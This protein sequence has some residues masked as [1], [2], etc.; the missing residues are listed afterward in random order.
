MI[1][2]HSKANFMWKT[3]ENILKFYSSES[4]MEKEGKTN[5]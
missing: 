4:R 2:F 1:F 5:D 3:L